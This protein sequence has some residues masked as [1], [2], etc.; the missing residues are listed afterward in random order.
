MNILAE[1]I[2]RPWYIDKEIAASYAW[3]VK[4]LFDGK[5]VFEGNRK[6]YEPRLITQSFSESS[7]SGQASKP[8]CVSIIPV[9][10]PLMRKDQACG[11]VGMNT[12]GNYIKE[13]NNDSSVDTIILDIDSPGG[14]VSGTAALGK[15]IRESKKPVIAYVNELAASAA[16]WLASQCDE[17][18]ASDEKAEIGSIGVMLS[19]MDVQ[20]AYELQGVKFHSIVS[21]L[22][23]D[24]NRDFDEVRKGN[25]KEYKETVL[26]PLAER[27]INTVKEGRG[28]KI[29]DESIFKGRVD[30]ADK[31]IEYGLIDSIGTMEFAIDR[32]YQ[33]SK[34]KG[35]NISPNANTAQITNQTNSLSMKKYPATLSALGL[36]ALESKDG[37]SFLN[38]AQLDKLEETLT[39]NQAQVDKVAGERDTAVAALETAQVA[40][41][42]ELKTQGS[43]IIALTTEVSEKT[44]QVEAILKSGGDQSA[45]QS[46]HSETDPDQTEG[47]AYMK[48]FNACGGDTAKEMEYL[49]KH[50]S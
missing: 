35:G 11:P 18:I 34:T 17:I 5:M 15:V 41:T 43:Q 46:I 30:F 21:N 3:A 16:Y 27:F 49:K 12:I 47:D 33:L 19:F 36:D 7:S 8:G 4:S 26:D 1:V 42:E 29:T 2:N 38:E 6:D 40:H 45:S 9:Q 28:N 22:S 14:T 48:G 13:A 25:Y 32:A 10:G 39:G 31:A 23:E 24:K 50:N 44:A 37:G 20:P